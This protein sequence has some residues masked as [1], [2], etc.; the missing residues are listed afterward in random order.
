M[1][2]ITFLRLAAGL[3]QLLAIGVPEVSAASWTV[4]EQPGLKQALE[5]APILHTESLGEPARELVTC[6]NE[7]RPTVGG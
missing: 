3:T 7:S 4:A 5:N 1:N 2:S 6:N